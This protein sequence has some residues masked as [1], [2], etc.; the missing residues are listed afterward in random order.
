MQTLRFITTLADMLLSPAWL[1]VY[2]F[3]APKANALV[4]GRHGSVHFRYPRAGFLHG[5]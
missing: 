2:A 4:R 1:L 5:A 3:R